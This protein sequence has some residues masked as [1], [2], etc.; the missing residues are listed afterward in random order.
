[1]AKQTKQN[2]E[3]T[4]LDRLLELGVLWG[5]KHE[6]LKDVIKASYNIKKYKSNGG[7]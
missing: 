6:T 2:P 5:I 4:Y 1:M 3:P 7:N